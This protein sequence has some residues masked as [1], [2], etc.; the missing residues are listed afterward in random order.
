MKVLIIED[1]KQLARSMGDYLLN[2]NFLC[3]F[4]YDFKTAWDKIL[5]YDY[6]CI[7]LDLTLPGGS[8][9]ALLQQLKKENKTDGVLIVSAKD[10]LDDKLEGLK[11]G[12][13]DY[14]SKPFH[15]AE[16]NARVNAIIR[17]KKFDGKNLLTF[18]EISIETITKRAFVGQHEILLTKME[19]ELLLFL[20]GNKGRVVSKE[21]IAEHLTGDNAECLDDFDFLYSHIKNIKR[22][23]LEAGGMDYIKAVY[24]VGYKWRY[25]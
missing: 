18:E 25:E 10:S 14:L 21:A 8:G 16:L 2:D 24:G 6:D 1:E 9:L 5:V 15:L 3:E 23:V 13:D 12:A 4:A 17:R 22:K 7:V 11:L 20:I 19:F